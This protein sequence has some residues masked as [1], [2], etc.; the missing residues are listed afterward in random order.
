M[1]L[2]GKHI[3]TSQSF[4]GIGSVLLDNIDNTQSVTTLWTNTNIQKKIRMFDRFLL[5]LDLLFIFGLVDY[6]EGTVM[7][8]KI[9]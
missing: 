7:K 2:P 5:G 1:I 6:K 3:K 8:I 9:S 4:L